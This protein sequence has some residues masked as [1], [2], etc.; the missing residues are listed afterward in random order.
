MCR[1]SKGI[2]YTLYV[3]VQLNEQTVLYVFS[4][5][6]TDRHTHET[7]NKKLVFSFFTFSFPFPVFTFI[8]TYAW[9]R[10]FIVRILKYSIFKT[11]WYFDSENEVISKMEIC[12]IKSPRFI[13]Y[14]VFCSVHTL[15]L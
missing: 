9:P 7:N 1:Y 14:T 5:S 4:M 13:I 15:S 10:F 6:Q 11:S 2:L 3:H 8:F 12:K